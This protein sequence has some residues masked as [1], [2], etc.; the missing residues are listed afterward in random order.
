MTI[1]PLFHHHRQIDGIA[2][3]LGGDAVTHM[4]RSGDG[5]VHRGLDAD[6]SGGQ[7]R[8]VGGGDALDIPGGIK[9]RSPGQVHQIVRQGDQLRPAGGDDHLQRQHH[10]V[11]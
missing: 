3:A 1:P 8:S 5:R 11:A 9:G 6:L 4:I 7:G 10:R 2:L